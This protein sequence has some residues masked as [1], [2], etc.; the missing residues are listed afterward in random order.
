MYLP[1]SALSALSG[2]LGQHTRQITIETA[3]TTDNLV[4]ER[5]TAKEAVSAP[6]VLHIDCL[7]P[8][9]HLDTAKLATEEI[10]LRLMLPDGSRRAWHGYVVGCA[11][12]GGDGGLARYRLT[13]GSWFDRLRTRS[14]CFVFQDKTALEIIEDVLAD[15]PLAHYRLAVNQP[16]AKRSSCSQY[17]ETDFAFIERLLAEEGL[18]YRFEHQQ[19]EAQSGDGKATQSRHCLVIFDNDAERPACAQPEIRF[20]RVDATEQ[21]DAIERFSQTHTVGTNA[22]TVAGWD[23]KALAA[24]SAQATAKDPG[25]ELPTLE[26][27]EASGPYRFKDAQ[28]ADRAARLRMQA[29]EGGYLRYQGQGSVRQ[30]GAGE[31]FTLMQHFD[32]RHSAF[33]T[34]QVEHEAANNLGADIA[35]LLDTTSIESGSYRNRF[36]AVPADAPIVPAYRKR[37]TAPEGQAAVVVANDG[38]PL[39]TDRD[40]RVLV[41]FPWLRAPDANAFR[42]PDSSD[43]T[44]VTAWVRVATSSAGPNWGANHLPRAG[45][46]V[47]LSFLDG[48]ID[49]PIAAMQLHSEQDALPWPT[50]DAPL[51]Q[52]L[53]GWHSQGLGGDG[54]NQWVV[55]DHP[56]QLRTRLASS[57]ASSQLSLGYVMSHSATGG[58]RG[59]W[60]GTGAELRTDAWAVVRAGGGLLLS[61]TARP[62][63]AGTVLDAH[64]A[65]GQLTAAQKTAQRLSDAASSQQALPLAANEAFDPLT[66]A[67]D[68]AQDG[69]YEDNVN[70]QDAIQPNKAPV[71]R[72]GQPW[73]VAESPTSIAL[74]SQATTTVYAGR[75]LH[76]TAQ[77]DW[78]LAAGNVVAA[79]AAK[80]VSLFA[81]R[82]S[83]RAIAEGGPVS[84]QAHTDALAVLADKAVTVTSSAESVEILAQQNVVL[85]G[86]DSMIRLEGNA[87]TFETSGV[88]SVKGAGHPLVG[89]GGQ[90]AELPPLPIGVIDLHNKLELNLTDDNLKPVPNAAY[91][92]L[93]NDGTVISGKLD[94]NGHAVLH[95][96]PNIGKVFFGED[97]RPFT[98]KPLSAAQDLHMDDVLEELQ[99]GGHQ[100]ADSDNLESLFKLFAGRPDLK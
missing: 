57:T 65:R 63:G 78:H 85:H 41:R 71:E 100:V 53:S 93:L 82:N 16:C 52:A 88:L 4:V 50:A 12:L 45:T 2:L 42:D 30:L 64:E 35:R 68:P 37:P 34:L 80:G 28:G 23:Y 29:H 89:P 55:D 67:L 15:Y 87:I 9:A 83:I 47:L 19:G 46:Q 61:T 90:A 96:V 49:R 40:H 84:I 7:S 94:G 79:A 20:H 56:G 86:G 54:Y 92:V 81:Q 22:V 66:Q 5:F 72:F 62:Q 70:G 38:A 26:S 33:V 69:R 36:V 11:S 14:D 59:S 43:R 31:R 25:G 10:T 44:Q 99:K 75:H 73:L 6:F 8:S 74:A 32:S 24:T 60:R 48:D 51:G 21:E 3:L 77:A 13:V 91:K 95:D 76:G 97:P 18:S 27:F 58:D 17:R 98:P 39:T 1:Q